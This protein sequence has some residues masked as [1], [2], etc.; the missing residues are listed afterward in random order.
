MCKTPNP[1]AKRNKKESNENLFKTNITANAS[2]T[3]FI[4]KFS[5]S[6]VKIV[7]LMSD[8]INVKAS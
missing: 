2:K 7:T 6:G 3:C 1:S 5:I 8:I 4:I